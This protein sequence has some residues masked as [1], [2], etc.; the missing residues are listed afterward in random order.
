MIK[1]SAH[2][3]TINQNGFETQYSPAPPTPIS[4][5]VHDSENKMGDG[6]ISCGCLGVRCLNLP[7]GD[8]TPCGEHPLRSKSFRC[9]SSPSPRID[10]QLIES[11]DMQLWANIYTIEI[12]SDECLTEV[13][14]LLSC[15]SNMN[16]ARSFR[17]ND[18]QTFIDFLDQVSRSCRS[19]PEN[20]VRYDITGSCAVVPR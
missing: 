10:Y 6:Y 14:S 17:G 20:Q 4:L 1:R 11:L 7:R 9:T 19:Y 3:F 8:S 2:P 15:R 13:R 12:T 18:A 16:V 5:S